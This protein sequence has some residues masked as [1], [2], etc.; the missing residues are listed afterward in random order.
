MPSDLRY[1]F[2]L[3]NR[4]SGCAELACVESGQFHDGPGDFLQADG[5]RVDILKAAAQ[6]G[7][8]LAAQGQIRR[9]DNPV[10]RVPDVVAQTGQQAVESLAR[11][12]IHPSRARMTRSLLPRGFAHSVDRRNQF[13]AL[14][15]KTVRPCLGREIAAGVG[16][17]RRK[18]TAQRRTDP[19]GRRKTRRKTGQGNGK[20]QH[21]R[22][23]TAH[24]IPGSRAGAEIQKYCRARQRGKGKRQEQARRAT[25]QVFLHHSLRKRRNRICKALSPGRRCALQSI[26]GI[27]LGKTALYGS[28]QAL[29][30]SRDIG[31]VLPVKAALYG[32]R[33]TLTT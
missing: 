28:P 30:M 19:T 11:R 1:D 13:R 6:T 16:F 10:Q 22:V 24:G 32:C 9:A 17:S 31:N 4:L 23:Q 26:S 3:G 2:G 33:Q 18:G 27:P 25:E 7:A 20:Q 29:K 12:G 15:Y 8:G 5:R 21:R 14:S